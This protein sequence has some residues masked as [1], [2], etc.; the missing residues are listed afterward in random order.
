MQG[1]ITGEIVLQFRSLYL[2]CQLI[3]QC[4][5][6]SQVARG[7]DDTT[8]RGDDG[9]PALCQQAPK[10]ENR[11]EVSLLQRE[12]KPGLL[13]WLTLVTSLHWNPAIIC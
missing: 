8:L 4:K 9:L 12:F 3:K 13:K 7:A 1:F 2:I 5:E 11:K 10:E 6:I